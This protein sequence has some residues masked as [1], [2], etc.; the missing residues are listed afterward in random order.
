MRR[1]RQ[2]ARSGTHSNEREGAFRIDSDTIGI[3]ELGGAGA[4]AVL[5]ALNARASERGCLRALE[6]DLPDAAV[7]AV[8][9]SRTQGARRARSARSK[10]A[11]HRMAVWS[12]T[13]EGCGAGVGRVWE[14]DARDAEARTLTS[15]KSPFGSIATP[16]G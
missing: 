14:V 6:V 16:I 4:D 9:T 10:L 13:S 3:E 11:T 2:G 15:A 8:L 7:T 1:L 12:L 5:E